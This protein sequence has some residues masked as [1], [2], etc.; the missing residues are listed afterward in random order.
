MYQSP[1]PDFHDPVGLS[2]PTALVVWT[3][4]GL[5]LLVLAFGPLVYQL[6]YRDES[7]YF[8][9]A[10]VYFVLAFGSYRHVLLRA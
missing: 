10:V 7:A 1:M 2:G 9:L 4:A 6:G 3:S 8:I 5:A